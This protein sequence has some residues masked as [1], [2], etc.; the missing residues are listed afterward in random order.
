[1]AVGST[2]RSNNQ[3]W[4]NLERDRKREAVI[5]AAFLGGRSQ[6][7]IADEVGISPSRVGQ[8]LKRLKREA[9]GV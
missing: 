2:G 5:W 3:A 9:E 4:L 7:S 1:M 6:R 8:I